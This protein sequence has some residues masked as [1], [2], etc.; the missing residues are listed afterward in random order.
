MNPKVRQI[1]DDLFRRPRSAAAATAIEAWCTAHEFRPTLLDVDNERRRRGLTPVW[2]RT[3][4]P[5]PQEGE[6]TMYTLVQLFELLHARNA[7]ITLDQVVNQATTSAVNIAPQ[8]GS[9]ELGKI[10]HT[11]AQVVATALAV[12]GW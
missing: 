9:R 2:L 3:D 6:L 5:P 10:S 4:T 7:A 11:S 8:G 1:P 12:T